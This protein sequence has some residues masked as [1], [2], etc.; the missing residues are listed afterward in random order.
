MD[1]TIAERWVQALKSGQYQQGQHELHP[2]ADSYCCLGV[3]CE[4]YRAEQ[5]KGEWRQGPMGGEHHIFTEGVDGDYE[6]AVLPKAVKDWAGMQSSVGEIVG[7]DDAL[8]ALNDEGMEF[9]Q[10]ADLIERNWE[11]L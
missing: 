9:S 11:V 10:L 1:R 2:E 7:T 8:S 6:T 4:L 3:L 5:G